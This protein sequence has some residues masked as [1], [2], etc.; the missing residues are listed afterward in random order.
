MAHINE[1]NLIL[2]TDSYKASQYKQYPQGS[3]RLFSYAESRG[4]VY[5]TTVFFG[6]QYLLKK[7]LSKPVT[8]SDVKEAKTFL[9]SMV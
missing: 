6:L 8:V 2:K 4:G 9:K 5:P 7:Y 3:S 1:N